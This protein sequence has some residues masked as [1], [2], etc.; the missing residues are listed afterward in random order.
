MAFIDEN[1]AEP[2]LVSLPK[3]TRTELKAYRQTKVYKNDNKEIKAEML[4]DY[5]DAVTDATP[6]IL[7]DNL[8]LRAYKSE[9]FQLADCLH[10]NLSKI[11]TFALDSIAKNPNDD[12]QFYID[13]ILQAYGIDYLIADDELTFTIDEQLEDTELLELEIKY[14][15]FL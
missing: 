11:Y 10:D 6:N 8:D 5:L 4:A 2:H 12:S 14:R 15:Y 9:V 7:D 13:G 1:K 3:K